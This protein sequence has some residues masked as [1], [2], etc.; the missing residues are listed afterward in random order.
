MHRAVWREP[1]VSADSS[2]QPS[3]SGAFEM[4]EDTA[5]EGMQFDHPPKMLETDL[6]SKTKHHT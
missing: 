5:D 6:T 4:S 3:P 1:R 2:G